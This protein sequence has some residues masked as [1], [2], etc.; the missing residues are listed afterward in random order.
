[1]RDIETE[2]LTLLALGPVRRRHLIHGKSARFLA[3]YQDLVN[4]GKIEER[5]YPGLLFQ[6]VYVC[7]PGQQ[8]PAPRITRPRRYDVRLLMNAGY[9]REQAIGA[10]VGNDFETVLGLLRSAEVKC[11]LQ[12][13]RGRGRPRKIVMSM[14]E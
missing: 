3:A 2:V 12:T 4:A 10:I 7:L 13:P 14:E 1:M 11:G 8:P 5:T 9:S 6:P